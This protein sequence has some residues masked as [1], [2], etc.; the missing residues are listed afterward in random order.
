MM[1][2]Y[3]ERVE[4]AIADLKHG[5]MVVL[6][7]HPDREN[8]GDII[9]PA[10]IITPDVI[11][12]M[13]KHCSGIICLSLLPEQSKK[14]GLSHMVSPS[15][16]TSKGGTPF[17]IP[18]DARHGITTGVSAKDRAT[19]ILAAI[20]DNAVE[21]DLVKPG[22]VFPLIAQEGGVL[23]RQGHTEGSLDIVSLAGFKPTAV[24]CEIMNPD[25]TMSSGDKLKEFAIEHEL[26]MLA[27]DDLIAYRLSREDM[28]AEEI[29]TELPLKNH[30]TFTMSVI[31]EKYTEKEHVT[32]TSQAGLSETPLV[33]IH[34]ACMTGD[35]FGSERCDCGQ[36][37]DYSLKRIAEEG[38]MLIYLNQEGRDIG[39]F[40][41]IKAYTLQEGGLDTVE[42]NK[43]LGLP[44][45]G[46]N[47]FIAANILRNK[48]ISSI[49][50]L[51][52]NMRKSDCLK[53]YGLEAVTIENMP[54]FS[55]EHNLHYLQ[56]KM[57]KLNHQIVFQ[58]QHND[59]IQLRD[60]G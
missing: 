58:E 48:D 57:K 1:Q 37:L 46:R 40:N 60:S 39:I 9:F 10:E 14:I 49:R 26:T 41:K 15:D 33:R 53:K 6:T 29:S 51:T 2:P 30:G 22:H 44:V 7:D 11:N 5:K 55:N 19:T 56:T 38:G 36:Q 28:I 13:I 52:N 18:I 59:T 16:N 25:G 50:L 34:S 43:K 45:D 21:S 27:I 32:L 35:L 17:T 12:F 20:N 4:K 23:Q 47:Y 3:V 42:A 24:I 31:R 8:E 54:A